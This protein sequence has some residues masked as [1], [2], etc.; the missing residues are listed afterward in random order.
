MNLRPQLTA[1][2][3]QE[4]RL[5]IPATLAEELGNLRDQPVKEI[6]LAAGHL[7]IHLKAIGP[8]A[9][10]PQVEPVYY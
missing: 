4:G 3:D 8:R 2:V 9:M 6:W 7:A 10:R 5:I 1:E